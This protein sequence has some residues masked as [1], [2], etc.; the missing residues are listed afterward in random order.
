[1]GVDSR[2]ESIAA[3]LSDIR[4]RLLQLSPTGNAGPTFFLP[5]SRRRRNVLPDS[6]RAHELNSTIQHG[7]QQAHRLDADP[8]KVVALCLEPIIIIGRPARF[9]DTL[10]HY[11]GAHGVDQRAPIKF[12]ILR[13]APGIGHFRLQG[14][15]Y[16]SNYNASRQLIFFGF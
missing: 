11:S 10:I 15:P 5:S 13:Q 6:A 3:R 8:T 7:G 16:S 9:L 2:L 12:P 14:H 1:V 4:N